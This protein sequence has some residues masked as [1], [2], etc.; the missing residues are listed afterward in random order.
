MSASKPKPTVARR[1][2]ADEANDL[3][4][5]LHAARVP[6]TKRLDE[7]AA[8]R[9]GVKL[10]DHLAEMVDHALDGPWSNEEVIELAVRVARK[11]AMSRV[12]QRRSA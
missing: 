9:R 7:L 10:G 11:I 2:V 6:I 4:R 1:I 12:M 3:R 5:R 8:M